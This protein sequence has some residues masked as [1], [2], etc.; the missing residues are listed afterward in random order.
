MKRALDAKL[1]SLADATE[2][3]LPEEDL[4][5]FEALVSNA[6]EAMH[7]FQPVLVEAIW[8]TQFG[9]GGLARASWGGD[10]SR[11][12]RIDALE[13]EGLLSES[14]SGLLEANSE[15]RRVRKARDTVKRLQDFLTH[16]SGEDFDAWFAEEYDFDTPSLAYRAV[17]DALF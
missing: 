17:W 9:D 6:R 3:L 5:R 12:T 16:E 4:E 13:K 10:P 15:S 7:N 14:T 2:L 1:Q 11:E 8:E